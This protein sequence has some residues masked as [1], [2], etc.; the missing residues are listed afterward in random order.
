MLMMIC[1]TTSVGAFKLEHAVSCCAHHSQP[2]KEATS[3]VLDQSLM[4]PHLVHV[5]RLTTFT[6][7]RLSRR[8]LELL[9]RQADGALD[10]EVL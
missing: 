10:A 2:P 3:H 8:H 9:G 1:L 7:R 6:A 4:N 5:P